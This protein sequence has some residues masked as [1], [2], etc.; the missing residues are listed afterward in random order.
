MMQ[1]LNYFFRLFPLSLVLGEAGGEPHGT[2]AFTIKHAV[3]DEALVTQVALTVVQ[4]D[5]YS[6]EIEHVA[7]D[8]AAQG[9]LRFS[10]GN[11]A[12]EFHFQFGGD[13]SNLKASREDPVGQFVTE[14]AD[15]ATV[16][17]FYPAVIVDVG[18]PCGD[19]VLAVFPK[20]QM[21][22]DGISR[23]AAEAVVTFLIK[24]WIDKLLHI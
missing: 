5:V 2:G 14:R 22:A 4:R 17:G 8:A 16:Q 9:N 21:Q 6:V 13:S 19:D 20:F 12:A 15:D 10:G 3:G 18:R 11:W 1:A 24:V 23:A 7:G